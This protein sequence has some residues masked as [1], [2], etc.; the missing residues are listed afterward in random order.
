MVLSFYAWFSYKIMI[1][2][3]LLWFLILIKIYIQ[4]KISKK[5][6]YKTFN[7]LVFKF[8]II[9]KFHFDLCVNLI[10]NTNQKVSSC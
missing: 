3:N 6:L 10:F 9:M 7:N 2:V 8:S 5:Y 4:L 1:N